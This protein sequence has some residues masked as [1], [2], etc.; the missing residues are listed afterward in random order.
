MRSTRLPVGK[1]AAIRRME[2]SVCETV[3]ETLRPLVRVVASVAL[4]FGSGGCSG[5]LWRPTITPLADAAVAEAP[6][7]VTTR[8]FANAES[9]RYVLSWARVEGDSLIGTVA[10]EYRRGSTGRWNM[11]GQTEPQRRIAVAIADISEVSRRVREP[12][13]ARTGALLL[14]LSAFAYFVVPRLFIPYG[15]ET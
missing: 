15:A 11:V 4:A 14:G 5:Y 7:Q 3:K 13:A 12:S 8:L 9:R 1:L 6:L 2:L 10:E